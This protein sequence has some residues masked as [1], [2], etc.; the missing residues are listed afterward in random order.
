M[1]TLDMLSVYDSMRLRHQSPI[2]VTLTRPRSYVGGAP[3]SVQVAYVQEQAVTQEDVDSPLGG[4]LDG[5]RKIFSLW[6]VECPALP[7]ANDYEITKADGTVWVIKK[8][9]TLARGRRFRC[10]CLA[11][12][13]TAG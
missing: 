10:H 7:P 6:L 9:E 11:R 8:T 3:A 5:S 12:V 1:V 13:G 4:S 2:T